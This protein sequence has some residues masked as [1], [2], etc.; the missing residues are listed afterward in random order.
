MASSMVT[1]GWW[2]M[3]FLAL[4]AVIVE[5]T[6]QCDWHWYE[7]GL[8]LDD[9]TD[10]HHQEGKQ[11]G[12]VAGHPVG[13]VVLGGLI[14]EACQDVGQECPERGDFMVDDVKCLLTQPHLRRGTLQPRYVCAPGSPQK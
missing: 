13:D 14:V 3:T 4:T 1:S 10:R 7:S 2:P 9:R 5:C 12:Q 8:E 6:G 11:G